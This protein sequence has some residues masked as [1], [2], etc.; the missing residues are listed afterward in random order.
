MG[1]PDHLK[2]NQTSSSTIAGTPSSQA[3]KYLPMSTSDNNRVD[4]CGAN[5][6]PE[7]R[8]AGGMLCAPHARRLPCRLAPPLAPER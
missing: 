4:L 8:P 6:V 5:A 3:M 7:Q 2:K 1:M